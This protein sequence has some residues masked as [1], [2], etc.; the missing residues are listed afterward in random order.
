MDYEGNVG[1]RRGIPGGFR[2]R[3]AAITVALGGFE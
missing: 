1:A 3:A 2:S